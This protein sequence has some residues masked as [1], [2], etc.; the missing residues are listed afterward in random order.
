MSLLYLIFTIFQVYFTILEIIFFT[1]PPITH[2][3]SVR[4]SFCKNSQCKESA[5]PDF[6]TGARFL[7]QPLSPGAEYG[8]RK[9]HKTQ[10]PPT[11]DQKV[12]PWGG[13]AFAY[14]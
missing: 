11:Q 5:L 14:L 9:A 8:P 4:K 3:I 2:L 10:K 13:V 12:I 6:R 7:Q 1:K